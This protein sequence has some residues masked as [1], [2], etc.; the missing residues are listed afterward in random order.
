MC[1]VEPP[2]P[3]LLYTLKL[4]ICI[5][6]SYSVPVHS[7]RILIIDRTQYSVQYLYRYRTQ[8]GY[9]TNL[10]VQLETYYLYCTITVRV[11]T[12]VPLPCCHRT[13][14]STELCTCTETSFSMCKMAKWCLST[15]KVADSL[16]LSI[17]TGQVCRCT[18]GIY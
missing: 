17:C 16:Q 9:V 11:R 15:C 18:H 7:V 14:S 6:H 1:S 2:I 4:C 12:E 5:I 10:Y 8:Y 3:V 13:Q